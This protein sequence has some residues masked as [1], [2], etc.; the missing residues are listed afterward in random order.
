MLTRCQK[1]TTQAEILYTERL[2]RETGVSTQVTRTVEAAS[3]T[4]T[5]WLDDSVT[6]S[7]A[8]TAC[9]TTEHATFLVQCCVA[10]TRPARVDSRVACMPEQREYER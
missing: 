10:R 6:Q 5:D 1:L 3:V 2:S 7:R 4:G 9:L 8:R